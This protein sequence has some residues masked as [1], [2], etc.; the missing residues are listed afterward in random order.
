MGLALLEAG[1]RQGFPLSGAGRG[2]S[3]LLPFEADG[4]ACARHPPGTGK[5]A[6]GMAFTEAGWELWDGALN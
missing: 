2:T 4:E 1:W 3:T 5:E 6:S